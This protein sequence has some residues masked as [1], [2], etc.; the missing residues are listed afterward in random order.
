MNMHDATEQAYKNGYTAGKRDAL[1]WI[2]VAMRLPDTEQ[3]TWIDEDGTS[4]ENEVSGWVWGIDADGT[5]VKVRYEAGPTFQGWFD[6]PGTTYN[7]THWMPLPEP[8]GG[9]CSM[10]RKPLATGILCG[11]LAAAAIFLYVTGCVWQ[12]KELLI[13]LTA[14]SAAFGLGLSLRADL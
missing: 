11:C 5:Q 9:R 14:I 6:D 10:I 12:I 4:F 3:D 8:P 1:K 13:V 7:I 2:P